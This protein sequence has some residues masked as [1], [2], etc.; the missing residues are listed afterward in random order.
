[1]FL[2]NWPENKK[3][4]IQKGWAG[5]SSDKPLPHVFW[6]GKISHDQLFRFASVIFHHGGAGT[7]ASSLHAGKPQLITPSIGDQFYWAK[8]MIRLGVGLRVSI[9]KWHIQAPR[10]IEK[11][12]RLDKFQKS[13]TRCAD[14]LGKEKGPENAVSK[15]G[16]FIKVKSVNH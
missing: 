2:D 5:F 14:L 6:V 1:L 16:Q 11:L 8:E 13:A 3:I 15:L 10:L 9:K 12:S 4:I 7:T